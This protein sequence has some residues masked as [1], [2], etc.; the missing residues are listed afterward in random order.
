MMCLLA[1]P[2]RGGHTGRRVRHQPG[3]GCHGPRTPAR[4]RKLGN[5]F[6]YASADISGSVT[7]AFTQGIEV[8][9]SLPLRWH[10]IKLPSLEQPFWFSALLISARPSCVY[11]KPVF[12]LSLFGTSSPSSCWAQ[13]FSQVLRASRPSS[14]FLLSLRTLWDSSFVSCV[15][16]HLWYAV[17]GCCKGQSEWTCFVVECEVQLA[18]AVT[19]VWEGAGWALCTLC[20]LCVLRRLPNPSTTDNLSGHLRGKEAA[21]AN[22]SPEER[23]K[24][25]W[26][27]HIARTLAVHW[28]L[29]HFPRRPGSRTVLRSNGLLILPLQWKDNLH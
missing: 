14:I 10:T 9:L 22:S 12:F 24:P 27:L 26:F 4:G 16:D 5:I 25:G 29:P 23:N 15:I 20:S 17:L 2:G 19:H 7:W 8:T 21:W 11:P 13:L 28:G 1:F 6:K 18:Q 3:S